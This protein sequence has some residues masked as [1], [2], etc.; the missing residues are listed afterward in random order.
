MK[1]KWDKL[2]IRSKNTITIRRTY[3]LKKLFPEQ[4][5]LSGKMNEEI[6]QNAWHI[7]IFNK[8]CVSKIKAQ[9]LEK[10]FNKLIRIKERQ[11]GKSQATLYVWFEDQEIQLCYNIISGITTDLP[12]RC[13]IK[14]VSLSS[15][16]HDFL[17]TCQK[18]AVPNSLFIPYEEVQF[19]KRGDEGFDDEDEDDVDYTAKVYIKFLNKPID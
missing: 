6:E 1:T 3:D 11:L 13:H 2:V 8:N 19:F 12:F 4:M 5:C 18:A 7:N 9:S 17:D 16:I 14:E 15:V 10:F